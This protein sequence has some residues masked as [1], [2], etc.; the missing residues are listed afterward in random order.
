MNNP[1]K[2]SKEYLQ[3]QHKLALHTVL[4]M[5]IFT[6]VNVVI[7]LTESTSY[8][9]CSLSTPY[10]LCLFGQLFDAEAGGST[11]LTTALVI[12]GIILAA[13]L[14]CWLLAKKRPGALY[15]ALVLF[16]LDTVALIWLCVEFDAFADNIIDLVVHAF[17]I[18]QM[19]WG[20]RC[21]AKAKGMPNPVP[22]TGADF[23][24]ANQ[25]EE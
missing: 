19:F 3:G 24:N 12:G 5:M 25:S 6:V 17:A 20:A 23:L 7:L 16:A 22:V 18:Y 8:F 21:A 10:Y 1:D 9:V 14:V 2:N 15:A 13:F 11:Y 4:I